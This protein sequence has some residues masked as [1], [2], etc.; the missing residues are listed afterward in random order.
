[1]KPSI[2]NKA[3]APGFRM[4]FLDVAVIVVG[5]LVSLLLGKKYW[6]LS[7]IVLFVLGH[8][9]I[10]CNVFRLSR[11]LELL[12]AGAFLALSPLTVL[13]WQGAVDMMEIMICITVV[14]IIIE[15]K[16]PSYHGIFW[17][18]INPNLTD[19]WEANLSGKKLY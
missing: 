17:R 9:F 1:L 14:L 15:I 4:S 16:K 7:P 18:Q 2:Q 19:W 10:F 6:P 11:L 12:W 3:F 8:F 13:D 5:I